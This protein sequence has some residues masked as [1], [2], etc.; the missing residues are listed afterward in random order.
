[1]NLDP[2]GEIGPGADEP[3]GGVAAIADA[4]EVDGAG[5]GDG[6][7]RQGIGVVDGQVAG[8]KVVRQSNVVDE[9]EGRA[10]AEQQCPAQRAW[11]FHRMGI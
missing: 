7:R 2:C 6:R 9:Q 4:A 3:V 8:A 5:L 1:M 11:L 10:G